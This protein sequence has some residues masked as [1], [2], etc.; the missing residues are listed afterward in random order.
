[1]VTLLIR[2]RVADYDVWR[3]RYDTAVARDGGL[4]LH[5][6]RVWRSQDDPNLVVIME[7]YDSRASAEALLN[8]PA[9]QA[10]MV[11]DGVDPSSVQLD[12][13]DSQDY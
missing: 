7:T 9:V 5:S 2:C 3:P 8:N 13:L 4:G 11:A 1:M 6:S 10:E 12:F